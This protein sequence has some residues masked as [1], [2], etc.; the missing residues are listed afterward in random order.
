MTCNYQSATAK[1]VIN[2]DGIILGTTENFG[3]MAGL[4]KDFF[5]RIYYDCIDKK[6]GLPVALYIRAGQDGLG[7]KRDIE[8]ILTGLSWKITQEPLILKGLYHASFIDE[9][10]ELGTNFSAGL[11]AGIY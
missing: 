1:D 4:T 8:S 3:S 11:E 7:A 6:Q 9:V 5:E 10:K 2:C